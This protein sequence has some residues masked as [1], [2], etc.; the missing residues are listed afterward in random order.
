[1]TRCR[2][3]FDGAERGAEL[4]RGLWL[5]GSEEEAEDPVV[6]FGVEDANARPSGV[7]SQVLECGRRVMNSLR[8]SRARS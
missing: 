7:R 4:G 6:D 3:A 1:V 8:R 5:A 2:V